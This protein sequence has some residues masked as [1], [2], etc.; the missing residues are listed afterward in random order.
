METKVITIDGGRIKV[1]THGSYVV[2]RY[3]N[4]EMWL[5]KEQA[6]ELGVDLLQR[7][8]EL[9]EESDSDYSGCLR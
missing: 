5:H 2:L 9:V 4:R 3:E 8:L 1:N 7:T 6:E